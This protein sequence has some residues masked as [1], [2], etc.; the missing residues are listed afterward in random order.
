VHFKGGDIVHMG[1]VFFNGSCPFID[2]AAAA[3]RWA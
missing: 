1:D 2:A 3:A